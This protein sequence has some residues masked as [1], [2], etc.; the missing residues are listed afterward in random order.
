MSKLSKIQIFVRKRFYYF[1][2]KLKLCMSNWFSRFREFDNFYLFLNIFLRKPGNKNIILEYVA[3]NTKFIFS[4]F[5]FIKFKINTENKIDY[6]TIYPCS[7]DIFEI[8]EDSKN[9]RLF[10]GVGNLASLDIIS[11]REP[12]IMFF[13]DIN[14][15]Q[16]KYLEF[17]INLIKK[18]AVRA[19]FLS[20]LFGKEYTEVSRI[21]EKMNRS[22]EDPC[23]MEN[24]FWKCSDKKQ[25]ADNM[26]KEFLDYQAI[27]QN[28]IFKG[29]VHKK[30]GTDV[31]GK[32]KVVTTFVLNDKNQINISKPFSVFPIYRDKGFLSSENRYKHLRN[33]LLNKPFILINEPLSADLISAV[34]NEFRYHEIL[35]WL[36]NILNP[37]FLSKNTYKLIDKILFLKFFSSKYCKINILEDQRRGFFKT[38][39]EDKIT[40]HW[41]AFRKVS[42][43]LTGECLEIVNVKDWLKEETELFNTKRVYYTDF[44]SS[45]KNYKSIFIHIL[46]GNGMDIE[47]YKKIVKEAFKR[48][49]RV[50]L[51]EHNSASKDFNNRNIG[52]TTKELI[53]MF[54]KPTI[55]EYSSGPKSK[56]RN[57]VML[58][59]SNYN[60]EF[61][62]N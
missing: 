15:A 9:S 58:Y 60:A 12:D 24:E 51:L 35:L 59:A 47:I 31:F 61:T 2:Y 4:G 8:E 44:L 1:Y 13:I 6:S 50:V 27:K 19:E 33:I 14:K 40:P 42:K 29:A 16:L 53:K 41:D 43:H 34:S 18:F 45:R 5:R 38:I 54:G 28:G 36:S 32:P 22:K 26:H 20:Q 57:I 48:S 46:I 7:D 56:K 52:L 11:N 30:I 39:N 17:I 49:E 10:L 62:Q 3:K 23:F 21:L 37:Y 55:L 25:Y